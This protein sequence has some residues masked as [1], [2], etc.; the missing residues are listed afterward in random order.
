MDLS[1]SKLMEAL[2][3]SNEV[4]VL[5]WG[6]PDNSSQALGRILSLGGDINTHNLLFAQNA[7]WLRVRCRTSNTP[8]DGSPSLDS[9]ANTIT[10]SLLQMV[11]TRA[12]DGTEA[13]YIN[14]KVESAD[15]TRPGDFTNWGNYSLVLGNEITGDRGWSG[16]LVDVRLYAEALSVQAIL[17]LYKSGPGAYRLPDDQGTV[18]EALFSA[19]PTTPL[20]GE[21]VQFKDEST[22]SP[23]SWLWTFGEGE[24]TSTEKNPSHI[25]N[26]AGEYT[27][28]LTV[29]NAN[30][31]SSATKTAY[32][33]VRTEVLQALFSASPTTPLVGET[34]Q[35]KDESIGSPTSWLWTFGEGEGTS[36]EKNPSHVYNRAGEYTV[37]LTVSNANGSSSATKTAYIK[38]R[39]EVLQALFSASPTTPL[40]GETVQFKDESIGSPTSWLWT[41]GEGEGTSTEKNPSHVY[42]RA[43][44]YTVTLTVSN[45]Y[46]SSS[47]TKTAYIKVRA[48]VLEAQFS[49]SPT[50]PLV[51]E[52]VQFKD[53]SI[54]SPTSWLWTF[55]EGEGTSTE[56]NPSHIYSRVGEYTVTLTVSN[57]N[58]SSSAT[59][60]AYIK[61][62][63]EVLEAQFSASP[64]TPLVGETVQFKDE[65]IGSPTSWLWTF[66]EGE[67]TSTEKNPSHIY[68]RAGE[69]TV[70][71][72]VSNANGSSLATKTAY[73]KVREEEL[74][75]VAQFRMS[76]DSGYVP[77]DVDFYDESQGNPVRWEWSFGDGANSSLQNPSHQYKT[78]GGYTVTLVVHDATGNTDNTFQTIT[79]WEEKEPPPRPEGEDGV[80]VVDLPFP[81][82]ATATYTPTRYVDDARGN[83]SND[84][85]GP[86]GGAWKT[87]GKAGSSASA[88]DVVLVAAGTYTSPLRITGNGT[89]SNPIVFL[90]DG[91]H[92][93]VVIKPSSQTPGIVAENRKWVLVENFY[94]DW[95][96]GY[97]ETMIDVQGAEHCTFRRITATNGKNAR[98]AHESQS[99]NARGMNAY[100]TQNCWFD[101]VVIAGSKI[102]ASFGKAGGYNYIS[103]CVFKDCGKHNMTFNDAETAGCTN[104]EHPNHPYNTL[105]YRCWFDRVWTGDN[106]QHVSPGCFNP[107]WQ[108]KWAFRNII[109]K[110]CVFSNSAENALDLKDS[111]NI[112][113][114]QCMFYAGVGSDG[115]QNPF[116]EHA[117]T[118]NV[119]AESNG[120]MWTIRKSIFWDC[121][122]GPTSY[123][124]GYVAAHNTMIHCNRNQKGP[125][126]D[127]M[128]TGRA[129]G[130]YGF[131]HNKAGRDQMIVNNLIFD[132]LGAEGSW[133]AATDANCRID[134]NAYG[135]N[136]GGDGLKWAKV[137][138][139]SN[140]WDG[141]NSFSNWQSW[142][143][144]LGVKGADANG[145]ADISPPFKNVPAYPDWETDGNHLEGNYD[146]RPKESSEVVGAAATMAVTTNSGGRTDE[147]IEVDNAYPFCDG[148]GMMVPD[149]VRIAGKERAEIVSVSYSQRRITIKNPGITWSQ[150][151]RVDFDYD[152]EHGGPTI[153]ALQPGD[154]KWWE[155]VA[156]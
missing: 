5:V 99:N 147:V 12:S 58:G 20:V 48:E 140:S 73:I 42:N 16:V 61:V 139:S 44:E 111:R 136:R 68:N 114:D 118:V 8:D 32:I 55:G 110:Q 22:G 124:Q 102:G 56:K 91:D 62:R 85:R 31:S 10:P 26:R 74:T 88:G 116:D 75:L 70:T 47:A 155:T 18:P 151:D 27:V 9:S 66:G 35:F 103:Y 133:S 1:A 127:T 83:D 63:T 108:N 60:T 113:L 107:N 137:K 38:V 120:E 40:V 80:T 144:G 126:N 121:S 128:V 130:Y 15:S 131:R 153:G 94:V 109:Y 150:G 36:T 11:Y 69:Y 50:T 78:A 123:W 33:K 92:G 152:D 2:R 4:T 43:G 86:G 82:A 39:T 84:G 24:G 125:G 90:G 57:A 59:K 106:I 135:E 143:A 104:Y 37:T 29:S 115:W 95:N 101:Q 6:I 34:V 100:S 105:F 87:L 112:Y 13:I 89:A 142:L 96:A 45:I 65:S 46:G 19:S 141:T 156:L 71:L 3:A 7:G 77:L 132:Q 97:D 76:R 21:T 81:R 64:T 30:G 28:T 52:T 17:E 93:E 154:E 23:T 54:G 119:G 146:F 41:F 25:Y 129:V 134:G 67:G 138:S 122:P 72:T 117:P 149:Y 49:A 53:E 98:Q 79:A 148:F 51:G 14:G 145:M